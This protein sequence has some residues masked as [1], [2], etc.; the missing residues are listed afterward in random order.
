[1]SDPESGLVSIADGVLSYYSD[2]HGTWSI[3]LSEVRKIEE[4][5]NSDGPCLDDYFYC[6]HTVLEEVIASFYASGWETVWPDLMQTFPGLR[7][8]S[9]CRSTND[10]SRILW[11]QET[12]KETKQPV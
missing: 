2:L 1:M 9:L 12:E 11:P 8:A 3:Q 4:F 6:F 5:T 10:K 7:E